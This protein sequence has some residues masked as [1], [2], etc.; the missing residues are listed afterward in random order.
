MM[1]AWQAAE[2][3]IFGGAR[4]AVSHRGPMTKLGGGAAF[5][6]ECVVNRAECHRELEARKRQQKNADKTDC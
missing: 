1:V 4:L 3:R 2:F 5:R 6:L